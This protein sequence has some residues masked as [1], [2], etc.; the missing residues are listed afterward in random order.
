MHREPLVL[1]RT[2]L[3]PACR[4]CHS[5]TH[6]EFNAAICCTLTP[7]DARVYLRRAERKGTFA[8]VSEERQGSA[9]RTRDK[10]KR[11]GAQ[12]GMFAAEQRHSRIKE[13]FFGSKQTPA[14]RGASKATAGA[15]SCVTHCSPRWS[16]G[17]LGPSGT[18]LAGSLTSPG[19]AFG[20]IERQSNRHRLLSLAIGRHEYAAGG[21]QVGAPARSG[22]SARP[23]ASHR[24]HTLRQ[25][26]LAQAGTNRGIPAS[27]NHTSSPARDAGAKEEIR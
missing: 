25:P 21:S 4:V 20:P 3:G 18:G 8:R 16:A 23:L 1:R 15:H 12:Q 9:L 10:P 13:I 17:P 2:P 19:S 5:S 6:S 14:P 27:P 11:Q 22:G 7:I 24:L 26:P